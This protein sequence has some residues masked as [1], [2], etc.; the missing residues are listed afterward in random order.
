MDR[1]IRQLISVHKN[2]GSMGRTRVVISRALLGITALTAVDAQQYEI[3]T[4]AGGAPASPTA[5][6]ALAADASGNV[7]FVD[8]YGYNHAAGRSNSVFKIDPSGSITR[9]AGNTRTDFSGDGGPG[10]SASLYSPQAV[11]VDRSGNVF[12]V[13]AGN[14]RV[15]RVS[16]DGRITTAAGGGTAVLGDGGPA[17]SGQLNYPNSIAVN[18]AGDL[19]IGEYGRVRKVTPDGIITTVAGGG[20][21]SP[22]DGG[23]A[24]SAQL[25][26][27]IGVAVDGS[28]DLFIAEEF[29]D[30]ESCA[31][32]YRVHKVTPDGIIAT[33]P[34]VPNCCY[35][36]IAVDDIGNLI[37]TDGRTVWRISPSGNQ[38]ALAGNGMYGK[39]FGD[40]G[41][42][43]QA[44]LN[45]PT[46]VAVGP[47]GDLFLADNLGRT[48]RR[49][50]SDG[51]IRTFA[52]IP[53]SAPD[54][55]DGGPA[56]NAQLQLAAQGLSIQSG[57]ASDAAG[58]LYIAETGAHRVRK[59]FPS[60]TIT[61][62]AGVGQAR[63]A[64]SPSNCLPLGDG[65]PA[66]S[67]PLTFPTS[68]AV[69]AAGNLFIA[70]S[71]DLRV[72]KVS[73]D[74]T[75]TTVA[76]NG[77]SPVWPGGL[78]N[79]GPAVNTPVIPYSVAVDRAGN[80]FIGEGN[81]ADTRKV[82][83]DGTISTLIS[84]NTVVPYFQYVE[85]MTVDLRGNLYVAGSDCSDGDTCYNGIQKI[86][87]AGDITLLATGANPYSL[88]PGSS[89]GDGGPA[90]QASIGFVSSLAVDS[91]GNLFIADLIGQRIREID[92]NGIITTVGGD[93]I[94]G[95]S[96]DGG[97]ATN[98]T[99]NYPFG[100][101]TD[102][103]GNVY[104]S[105]FNQAVR[106]LRPSRQ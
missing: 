24:T 54:S 59:V 101:A 56:I 17:T 60:G 80:L 27:A 30:P 33:L 85:A 1:R 9:L 74:G 77:N 34:V 28:G 45:G 87:P 82:S 79:G 91:T 25:G 4:Y 68:V 53:N 46:A 63:C 62:V 57:L 86:S 23:P 8:G 96:G 67:A 64:T 43:T 94:P 71:A 44:Q 76:G 97:P 11:A 72:R 83:P 89:I 48:V 99:L 42:A 49:V 39:P 88:Q 104:V 55:G 69:D 20:A 12:I 70:D 22:G 98:A 5:A 61:T 38:T 47:A 75:I 81:F 3:S 26:A 35:V 32:L 37:T 10:T 51:I 21:N 93:G 100:L 40:G 73:P 95:Y 16:S 84:P 92:T 103:G 31:T 105:D 7:Y 6:I 15:R 18:S 36:G 50:A 13:D 102:T 41:P 78:G 58:N 52:S 14:Q 66:T 106:I 65:G 19:F 2:G 29:Y 90:L